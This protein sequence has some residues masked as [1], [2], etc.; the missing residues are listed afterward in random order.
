[1]H[2]VAIKTEQEQ[3]LA[4]HHRVRDLLMKQR[5]M[6]TSQI[7]GLMAEFGI[8]AAKGRRGLHD[9]A[10]RGLQASFRAARSPSPCRAIRIPL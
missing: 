2:F 8:V 9:G 4:G 3:A 5:T 1:M 6:L 7:C 10:T